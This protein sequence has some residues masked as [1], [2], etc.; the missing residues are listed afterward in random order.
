MKYYRKRKRKIY[1]GTNG[2]LGHNLIP[3]CGRFSQ[4]ELNTLYRVDGI[5]LRG[6]GGWFTFDCLGRTFTGLYFP[7]SLDDKRPGSKTIF[8][9]E[10]GNVIDFRRM[11]RHTL[12]AAL[13]FL[14]IRDKFG[15]TEEE[16]IKLFGDRLY[17]KE[18]K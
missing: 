11:F 4:E 18:K 2:R 13:K 17:Y 14:Q 16:I 5:E 8:M 3:I 6:R 10:K 9:I 15:Y 12:F 7:Y 1:F